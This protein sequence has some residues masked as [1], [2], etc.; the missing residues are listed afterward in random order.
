[1]S[2]PNDEFTGC[3]VASQSLVY[4]WPRRA[5]FERIALTEIVDDWKTCRTTTLMR[6]DGQQW[7]RRCHSK[8]MD[9]G[10]VTVFFQVFDERPVVADRSEVPT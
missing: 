2:Q 3:R 9:N 1:M 4:V 5:D 8:P 10:A 7:E 6:N